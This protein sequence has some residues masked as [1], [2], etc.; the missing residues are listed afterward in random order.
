[1]SEE[2]K[3]PFDPLENGSSKLE[4]GSISFRHWHGIAWDEVTWSVDVVMQ[5][6]SQ[7]HI[8]HDKDLSK[9][10]AQSQSHKARGHKP[11]K[12]FN[13]S[14]LCDADTKLMHKTQI[15]RRASYEGLHP[16][17]RHRHVGCLAISG[18]TPWFAFKKWRFAP[19][20][21][22]QDG[23]NHCSKWLG[24]SGQ[25]FQAVCH[26]T[27]SQGEYIM[28]LHE[29]WLDY[30]LL[31]ARVPEKEL[32]PTKTWNTSIFPTFGNIPIL[33][34]LL[35]AETPTPPNAAMWPM[36][37]HNLHFG[38]RVEL[39]H[40]CRWMATES[41]PNLHLDKHLASWLSKVT[42]VLPPLPTL[43]CFSLTKHKQPKP[44]L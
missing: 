12:S 1:M 39:C 17:S 30:I 43:V 11:H 19:L 40:W 28:N 10:V 27:F 37:L 7:H 41:P 21:T 29:A 8:S 20:E 34:C 9:Q 3:L 35:K 25:A 18:L 24:T 5:W 4:T 26:S 32:E 13:I 14:V 42:C 22:R 16:F 33:S 44:H 6:E 15:E 36:L 31:S 2:G 38:E 23:A